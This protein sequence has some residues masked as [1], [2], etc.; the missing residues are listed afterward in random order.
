MSICARKIKGKTPTSSTRTLEMAARSTG[1][2]LSIDV[3]TSNVK[4][5]LV[6][7]NSAQVAYTEKDALFPPDVPE[8]AVGGVFRVLETC[9]DRLEEKVG[10]SLKAV[11][12]IG[13]CGQM[14]GCVLWNSEK[15]T[16][17]AA[18]ASS[19]GAGVSGSGRLHLSPPEEAASPFITWQDNRCSS[20]FVDSL[21]RPPHLAR[22]LVSAGYGCATL[23]WLHKYDRERLSKYDRAGTIMDLVVAALC[24]GGR[25]PMKMSSHNAA[26]WGYFDVSASRWLRDQ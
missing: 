1:Y 17:F 3:G 13:V 26:G 23:A 15:A 14:H 21:P 25:R 9:M 11:T 16:L 5:V 24:S 18:T 8:R 20:E 7:C 6:D 2:V 19:G 10:A 4:T 22:P 12:A